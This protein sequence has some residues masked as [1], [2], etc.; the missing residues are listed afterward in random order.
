MFMA[1]YRELYK[2]LTLTITQRL[3]IDF[4]FKDNETSVPL[5]ISRNIV[6]EIPES[7][8]PNEEHDD[9]QNIATDNSDI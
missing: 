2:G 6:E 1:S 5:Q 4:I 3:I 7:F 8:S 9:N